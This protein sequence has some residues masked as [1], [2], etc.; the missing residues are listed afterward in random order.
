[1]T[2]RTPLNV[3]LLERKALLSELSVG[4][5]TDESVYSVGQSVQLTF[6]ETNHTNKPVLADEGP[7]IDGFV[8]EQNGTTVWR[9]NSGVNPMFIAVHTLQPGQSLTLTATW[10]GVPNVGNATSS[11]DTGTFV[12]LNQI[13]PR[14]TATFQIVGPSTQPVT[15]I[16]PSSP[17]P[18]GPTAPVPPSTPPISVP[19]PAPIVGT[20]VA[21]STTSKH[22]HAVHDNTHHG[23]AKMTHIT[24]SLSRDHH[25][26]PGTK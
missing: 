10:N 15:P 12:A 13:N 1:M 7:S 2:R 5:T 22:H 14:A 11:I 6:T 8:I 20:P 17:S 3:E 24:Q 25:P 9:S 18:T 21:S 19:S 4:L 23:M 26:R 16:S